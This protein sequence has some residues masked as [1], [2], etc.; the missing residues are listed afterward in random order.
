M[1]KNNKDEIEDTREKSRRLRKEKQ[2]LKQTTKREVVEKE[3]F[4]HRAAQKSRENINSSHFN[5][6]PGSPS[7]CFPGSFFSLLT[8]FCPGAFNPLLLSASAH[9][10]SNN[11]TSFYSDNS[12]SLYYGLSSPVLSSFFFH[13]FYLFHLLPLT[14]PTLLFLVALILQLH[15]PTLFIHILRSAIF[16]SLSL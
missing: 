1:D 4:R 14:F 2:H 10:C 15:P 9:F 5:S 7:S 3:G 12:F 11:S 13:P 16:L 8:L 6:L